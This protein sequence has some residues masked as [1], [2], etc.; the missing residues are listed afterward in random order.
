MYVFIFCWSIRN[1]LSMGSP[2]HESKIAYSWI[3]PHVAKAGF[4]L[5]VVVIVVV[6][7]QLITYDPHANG[8]VKT[9]KKTNS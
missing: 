3:S 9:A 7:S 1:D 6:T 4:I 8:V 5:G 2:T